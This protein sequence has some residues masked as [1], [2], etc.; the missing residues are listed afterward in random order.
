MNMTI[1]L[2]DKKYTSD[3]VT[4]EDLLKQYTEYDIISH[5]IGDFKLG[6]T[7]R[8]PIRSGD[9]FPSFNIFYSDRLGCLLFKDFAGKRGDFIKL[10][11]E[12]LAIP[13]YH[14]TIDRIAKDML[15]HNSIISQ[16]KQPLMASKVNCDLKIKVRSWMD[17]D[18]YYWNEYGI[19]LDTLKFF[20]VVPIE[21]YFHDNHYIRTDDIAY[22]YLEYKDKV[23]TYKIYRPTADKD[24]KWR[25]NNPYGVH[26]GYMQLPVMNKLLIIT[27]SLKDVMSLY[28][29]S[30]L[31]SI[32]VQSETCFI[33][34]T[35]VFEYK[36]RFD[37][38]LSLFDNDEQG[39]RQAESYQKLYEIQ[40]I[41][42]PIQYVAKDYSDL[43]KKVGKFNANRILNELL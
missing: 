29:V 12:L 8:S 38:V 22:A 25:N 1:N 37:R 43:I 41:F 18:V 33:K 15:S 6:E 7:F 19:S 27:K 3:K 31:N 14:E 11:Q 17:R 34:D 10:V 9:T 4:K 39:K 2:N 23:L 32:G 26:A 24:K 40:P 20:N 35:V 16:P 5:Y 30:K 21:G 13:T 36:A 42:I 28:E